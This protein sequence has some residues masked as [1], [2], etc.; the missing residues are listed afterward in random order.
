MRSGYVPKENFS[1]VLLII[2]DLSPTF[3]RIFSSVSEIGRIRTYAIIFSSTLIRNSR[4]DCLIYRNL[5]FGRFGWKIVF[6]INERMNGEKS[7]CKKCVQN[8]LS[9]T[10]SQPANHCV[11]SDSNL[12]IKNSICPSKIE[13]FKILLN[14]DSLS[15]SGWIH[16]SS[17]SHLAN[18]SSSP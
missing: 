7:Q 14:F 13:S 17:F 11:N 5:N 1:L 6:L 2:T 4:I 15:L 3:S 16:G 12:Q 8:E 18:S 9:N 10:A